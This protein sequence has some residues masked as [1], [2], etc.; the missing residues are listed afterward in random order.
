M[1]HALEPWGNAPGPVVGGGADPV[2]LE[3]RLAD[4]RSRRARVLAARAEDAPAP[5][6]AAGRPAVARFVPPARRRLRPA[7]LLPAFGIGLAAGAAATLL[8]PA[9]TGPPPVAPPVVLT[10]AALVPPPATLAAPQPAAGVGVALPP[11]PELA[12]APAPDARPR[13]AAPPPASRFVLALG[14]AAPPGPVSTS[15]AGFDPGHLAPSVR[16]AFPRSSSAPVE[17]AALSAW[18]KGTTVRPAASRATAST[19]SGA[20]AA[21]PRNPIAALFHAIGRLANGRGR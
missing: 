7:I 12:A 16:A 15:A 14:T 17:L 5:V 20:A 13:L 19:S 6:L 21:P 9:L 1:T 10:A 18:P 11:L 8:V 2:A 4:A 3:D